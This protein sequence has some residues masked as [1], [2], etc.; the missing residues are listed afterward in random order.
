MPKVSVIVPVYNAEKCIERCI[1]SILD[2]EY[3]DLEVIAVDDGSKDRSS[4]ILDQL[5]SED[6][7]LC[8]VH[9][10]NMYNF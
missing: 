2:Q 1:R 3:K 8:V 10:E 4:Q 5:A 9:K 6:S 7:R